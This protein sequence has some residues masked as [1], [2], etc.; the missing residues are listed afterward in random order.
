MSR[1]IWS[2]SECKTERVWGD[3]PCED[4]HRVVYLICEG[5][6]NAKNPIPIHT[7]HSFDRMSMSVEKTET[8]AL[9]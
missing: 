1:Q 4:T 5:K 7:I 8:G 3:G 9:R 2:C 6:C